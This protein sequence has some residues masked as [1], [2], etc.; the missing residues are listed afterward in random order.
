MLIG[1]WNA[2]QTWS[3]LQALRKFRKQKWKEQIEDWL[4]DVES[5]AETVGI[6]FLVPITPVVPLQSNNVVPATGHVF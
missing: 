3:Q 6:P 4:A 5:N 1:N 2:D